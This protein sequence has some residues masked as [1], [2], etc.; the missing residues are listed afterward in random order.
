LLVFSALRES[1]NTCASIIYVEHRCQYIKGHRA[2]IRNDKKEKKI[3]L[4]YREIQSGAVS[5]S[6]KRKGFLLYCMRKCEN[7]SPYMRRPLVIYDF[8]TAPL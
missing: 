4:I 5:K 2:A 6:Y 1:L 7:I 3:F 8:E